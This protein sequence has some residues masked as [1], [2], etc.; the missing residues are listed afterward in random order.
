MNV[1]LRE[2]NGDPGLGQGLVHPQVDAVERLE[3]LLGRH[4]VTH[5]D[6]DRGI[7]E[8]LDADLRGGIA[9]DLCDSAQ[10]LRDRL[11]RRLRVILVGDANPGFHHLV[12]E[13][14]AQHLADNVLVG[15]GDQLPVLGGQD[16][17]RKPDLLDHAIDALDGDGVAD[18]EGARKND[19]Q[20]RPVIGKGA[21][22]SEAATED[23]G[24]QGGDER[25]D[26]DAELGDGRDDDE[27]QHQ[28]FDGIAEKSRQSEVEALFLAE[29]A[30]NPSQPT[31][32]LA[33]DQQDDDGADDLKAVVDQE[34]GDDVIDLLNGLEI[35]SHDRPLVN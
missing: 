33:T 21:G 9:A 18:D 3:I 13:G 30:D 24:T 5:A 23:H 34:F 4:P 14:I 12:G 16:G 35:L 31:G 8:V 17:G 29:L 25:G 20:S 27:D 22:E 1:P 19:D 32:E 15:D 26:G 7:A 6:L 2:G 11:D 28:D 10:D